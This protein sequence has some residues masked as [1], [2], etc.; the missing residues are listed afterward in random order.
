M[1]ETIFSRLGLFGPKN[2]KRPKTTEHN[3]HSLHIYWG[4]KAAGA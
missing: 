1:S 2:Y 3:L 4:V